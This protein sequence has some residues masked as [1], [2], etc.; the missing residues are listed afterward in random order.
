MSRRPSVSPRRPQAFTLVELL[1]VIGI[2]ALLISMLLPALNR[3][4]EAANQVKCLSNMRQI[5]QGILSFAA[6][7]K[8]WMPGRGGSGMTRVTPGGS[9]QN[10]GPIEGT[11]DWIAWQRVTDPITGESTGGADQ[12]I[13][14]SGIAKYLGAQLKV[15]ATPEEANQIGDKLNEL[16]R[17]PSDSL[18]ARPN[19]TDR[20]YR[21]SYSANI[22]VMNPVYT[23]W[24]TDKGKRFDHSFSGKVSSVKNASEKVLL[25]CEDEQTLDD[26]TFSPNPYNW[27]SGRVNSVAARHQAR[28][29]SARSVAMPALE[30]NDAKGNV[31]FVD[32]HAE[33]FTRKDALRQRHTG[34]PLPDP[35]GF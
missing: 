12:N 3:A 34:N 22:L 26:G 33:F 11:A 19:Q 10:G 18:V 25:V 6:E 13:T 16:Y 27:F 17:C 1:V 35:A 24:G 21:F 7:N 4:R 30:N 31:A 28:R 14:Y 32:G 9:V 8:G 29:A 2:I 15:H 23:V 20:F 5:S